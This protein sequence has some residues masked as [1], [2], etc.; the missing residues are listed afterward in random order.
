MQS[1]TSCANINF[2]IISCVSLWYTLWQKSN[3]Q[4]LSLIEQIRWV[5]IWLMRWL[6]D[7]I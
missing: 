5:Q 4:Y 7:G 6:I 1:K 3:Y 2:T